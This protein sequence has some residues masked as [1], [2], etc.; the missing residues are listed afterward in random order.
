MRELQFNELKIGMVIGRPVKKLD[1][2]L[3]DE[4]TIIKPSTINLLRQRQIKKLFV[5]DSS[6]I[7]K[8]LKTTMGETFRESIEVSTGSI[9][10]KVKQGV[11]VSG[12]AISQTID[13]VLELIGIGLNAMV[14]LYHIADNESYMYPHSINTAILSVILAK[15]LNLDDEMILNIGTG[16][17]LHDVGM[18]NIPAYI[19]SKNEKLT[20]EERKIIQSHPE[21]GMHEISRIPN[22]SP[23]VVNIIWQHQERMD[24]SGYPQGLSGDDISFETR[25]VMICDVYEALTSVRSYRDS[26]IEFE[27]LKM[28]VNDTNNHLDGEILQEFIKIIP[29]Y[30][31]NSI[32]ELSNGQKGIVIGMTKNPFRPVI[33]LLDKNNQ[34]TGVEVN[35]AM[36]KYFKMFIIG[37]PGI[38]GGEVK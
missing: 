3:F 4:G 25:I 17:L 33:E 21:L 5:F 9:L 31:I 10:D 24:G 7:S 6:E 29:I 30:P 16:A 27:A 8:E 37:T 1:K 13:Q 11:L 23:E 15:Q 22:I 12:D 36:S 34:K 35:L 19:Y 14:N 38:L 18:F 20:D 28:M 2:I 26:M 32:V